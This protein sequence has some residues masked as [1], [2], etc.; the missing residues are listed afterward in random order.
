MD[1]T[2]ARSGLS[3]LSEAH[4]RREIE[5][6][7]ESIVRDADSDD[8]ADME[9][10][11]MDSFY[12]ADGND[13]IKKMTNLTIPEFRKI[14]G[15][16]HGYVI[17][18]WNVGRGR[19]S[20]VKPMDA[21]FLTL[22]VLKHGGSWDILARVFR[23]KAPTFERLVIGF[24][25]V[26]APRMHKLYVQNVADIYSMVH[27]QEKDKTFRNFAYAVEAI[28]VTFQLSNRP[29]GNVAEGKKY[30]SGKHKNYGYKVEVAVRANGFA[31]AYSKHYPGSV[32]DMTILTERIDKHRWR[33][34]KSEEDREL[35]DNY[36]MADKYP[37]HW[38]FLADKGYQGAQD[39]ARCMIPSKKPA[40]GVLTAAQEA[41]NRELAA[42][43]ILVE[44][45]FGRMLC[46]WNVMSTK[47]RWSEE[48]YDTIAGLCIAL[49]NVHIDYH[50]LRRTDGDWYVR[51]VNRVFKIGE[52]KKRKRA[53]TQRL[54]REKRRQYLRFGYADD[55]PEES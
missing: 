18:K 33:L 21:F 40:R 5:I 47:Y 22:T 10:P 31:S 51:Y 26:I 43:R 37:N 36:H 41:A 8:E 25:R 24:M 1:T 27:L 55:E 29:S 42:D 23:M 52:E 49:T 39:Q 30:F 15:Q 53:E 11:I 16:I 48:L 34:E 35:P 2:H 50:E 12:E 7:R 46:L 9:C 28:D 32:S 3:V 4:T 54:Y 17:T 6:S 19:K 44:N 14:Y 38:A 13:G 20:S 45:F